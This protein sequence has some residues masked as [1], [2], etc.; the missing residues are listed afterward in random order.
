MEL[1]DNKLAHWGEV[2]IVRQSSHQVTFKLKGSTIIAVR[3]EDDTPS[4]SDEEVAR[5][6]GINITFAH[7]VRPVFNAPLRSADMHTCTHTCSGAQAERI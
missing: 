6:A 2:T 4:E 5:G 7:Q 1:Y 3:E